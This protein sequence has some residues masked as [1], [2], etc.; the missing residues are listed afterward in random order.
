M[1]TGIDTQCQVYTTTTEHAMHPVAITCG[2]CNL[3]CLCLHL[4]LFSFLLLLSGDVEVNPGPGT[5]GNKVI[6]QCASYIAIALF[7]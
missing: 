6:L 2:D 3:I 4:V 1:C 5:P 7:R